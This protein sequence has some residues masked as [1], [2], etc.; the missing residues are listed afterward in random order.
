MLA[1]LA[2]AGS[3]LAACGSTPSR[4]NT[5][6]KP[7]IINHPG[8]PLTHDQA[9]ICLDGN[10]PMTITGITPEPLARLSLL[11]VSDVSIRDISSCGGTP[12]P[13]VTDE[14]LPA[15]L[16]ATH[17][18]NL[19]EIVFKAEATGNGNS[20]GGFEIT[21][22]TTNSQNPSHEFVVA[23]PPLQAIIGQ[24]VIATDK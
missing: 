8:L 6:P 19:F 5:E 15:Y 22:Y 20:I 10:E 11:Q 18:R 3:T 9:A 1:G 7:D 12:Y 17:K 23:S 14:K 13:K 24:K 16:P 21:Y 4:H 2:L